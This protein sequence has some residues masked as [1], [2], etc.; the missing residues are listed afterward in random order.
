[1]RE[2]VEFETEKGGLQPNGSLKNVE[3]SGLFMGM[4][5]VNTDEDV[6]EM[7][8]AVN[9]RDESS[10]MKITGYRCKDYC[11]IDPVEDPDVKTELLWS[12]IDTWPHLGRVPEEGDEV[13]IKSGWEVTYD[14][15]TSPILKSLEVNGK[16]TF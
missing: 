1:M 10:S 14:V 4:N 13:E 7:R 6:Q 2:V 3:E 9:G 5:D 16:L 15:G 12:D 8:F 11:K